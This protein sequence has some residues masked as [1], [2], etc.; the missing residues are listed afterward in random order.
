M[1]YET[2][3][4]KKDKGKMENLGADVSMSSQGPWQQVRINET[5]E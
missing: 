2:I 3:S 1:V 5:A 4:I